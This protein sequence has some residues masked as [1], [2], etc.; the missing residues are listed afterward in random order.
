MPC[1]GLKNVDRF[2]DRHGKPRHY[3]RARRG[4]RLR[5]PGEPGSD[6]FMEAYHRAA[7][8]LAHHSDATERTSALRE[9]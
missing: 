8:E 1:T 7:L 9:F 6:E 3:F 4:K 2:V 5:L